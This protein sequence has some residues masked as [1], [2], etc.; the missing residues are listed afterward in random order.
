VLFV[1]KKSSSF[2]LFDFVGIQQKK[3]MFIFGNHSG[4]GLSY[5]TIHKATKR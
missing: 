3:L 2:G 1:W 4:V 5:W